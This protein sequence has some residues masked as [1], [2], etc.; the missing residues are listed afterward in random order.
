MSFHFHHDGDVSD[1]SYDDVYDFSCSYS[2]PHCCFLPSCYVYDGDDDLYY[3]DY[4]YDYHGGGGLIRRLKL[5]PLFVDVHDDALKFFLLNKLVG[6]MYQHDSQAAFF[7]DQNDSLAY[8]FHDDVN[9][10]FGGSPKSYMFVGPL[11]NHLQ[12]PF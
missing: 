6:A 12:W 7:L 10:A 2:H 1:V 5:M 9:D 4:F 8:P 11:I 3:D